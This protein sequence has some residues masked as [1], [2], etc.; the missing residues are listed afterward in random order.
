MKLNKLV[1]KLNKLLEQNPELAD[2]HVFLWD[3]HGERY[4]GFNNLMKYRKKGFV[5]KGM[6]D[7]DCFGEDE[8]AY[9]IKEAKEFHC[10][11]SLTSKDFDQVVLL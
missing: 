10:D 4:A 11:E 6:G 2:K 3:E 1:Q 9:T 7:S 5:D 8:V